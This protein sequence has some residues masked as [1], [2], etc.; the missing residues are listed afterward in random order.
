MLSAVLAKHYVVH[1][2]DA[3]G[4]LG[5]GTDDRNLVDS[6]EKHD[7]VV[8]FAVDVHAESYQ[9]LDLHT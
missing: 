5:D 8:W 1:T 2:H 3:R 7:R 9:R 6:T 4:F